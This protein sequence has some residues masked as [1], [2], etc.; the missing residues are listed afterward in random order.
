R[1]GVVVVSLRLGAGGEPGVVAARV[2]GAAGGVVAASGSGEARISGAEA[3][4]RGGV[5]ALPPEI[6]AIMEHPLYRYARWSIYVADL[7]TGAPLYDHQGREL[8]VPG[9]VTK[10]F[11]GAAALDAYG[12]DYRFETPVYRRCEV[13]GHGALL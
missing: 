11:P 12:P 8:V 2:S 10:L 5:E 9:S 3:G 6:R 1:S 7:R 4:A 13:D